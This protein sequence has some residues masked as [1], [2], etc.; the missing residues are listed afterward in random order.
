MEIP[1]GG[2]STVKSPRME[3]PRGGGQ[4]GKTGYFLEPNIFMIG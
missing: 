3:N 1:G 2:M 4:T